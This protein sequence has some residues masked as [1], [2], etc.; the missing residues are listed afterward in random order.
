ML[1]LL[2]CSARPLTTYFATQNKGKLQLFP[3]E[4][5][6]SLKKAVIYPYF[7]SRSM[8]WVGADCRLK[9]KAQYLASFSAVADEDQEENWKLLS[10]FVGYRNWH[11]GT[12][13]LLARSWPRST[14]ENWT[15]RSKSSKIPEHR[16]SDCFLTARSSTFL[17][18]Q[19]IKMIH[20]SH[21]Q[22]QIRLI[23]ARAVQAT[24]K[25]G[26]LESYWFLHGVMPSSDS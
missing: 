25:V 19:P 5:V 14:W 18:M 4:S 6:N 24:K 8:L 16:R 26:V 21:Q 13:A 9:V 3:A 20:L 12:V 23:L 15:R 1:S 7:G 17:Q 10:T 22:R 2:I 11:S